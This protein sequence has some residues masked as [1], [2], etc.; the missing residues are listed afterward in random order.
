MRTVL[1]FISLVFI[2]ASASPA[3]SADS[4]NEELQSLVDQ[5]QDIS[6]KARKERAADRWLLNALEDLVERYNWPWRNELLAEDF[7][8]GDYTQDPAWQVL[9]GQ[10]W[11]DGRLGLRS[12][13]QAEAD[14]PREE[15]QQ[16]EEKQDIR[17]A[18][19]G[20]LLNQAFRSDR[21]REETKPEP[22]PVQPRRNEPAE[23]QL[24][25]KIPSAFAVQV[26]FS[27]HNAPNENGQIEFSIYQGRESSSGYRLVLYTGRQT[28]MELLSRRSGRTSVID[29]VDFDD[30]S[31]GRSHSLEWRRDANGQVEILLDEKQLMRTRDNSFR[32][33]FKQ[34][35]IVNRSGDFA[36]GNIALHGGKE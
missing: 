13:S 34:L 30:I 11:V 1:A 32:Y 22:E 24:P 7:S 36:V 4:E 15:K 10:F 6:V 18:M 8:D 21:Q 27:V 14:T 17:S 23:I 26:E 12:R 28:S 33:P 20:A 9:S 19:L 3:F 31:D 2:S 16:K 29:S 5:L 35:S 25:L